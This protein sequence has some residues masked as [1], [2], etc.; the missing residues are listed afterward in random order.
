MDINKYWE[1]VKEHEYQKQL[2][3]SNTLDVTIMLTNECNFR[4]EYCFELNKEPTFLTKETIIPFIDAMFDFEDHKD[5]WKDFYLDDR[6]YRHIHFLFFGGEPFLNIKLV[7][8]ILDYFKKKCDENPEKYQ[9]RW[10]DM[11]G[12]IITNGSL[13]KTKDADEFFKKWGNRIGVAVTCEGCKEFHDAGRKTKD[14]KP[15]FDMCLDGIYYVKEKY[16]KNCNVQGI[17]VT[18]KNVQYIYKAYLGM[19]KI[20]NFIK[21]QL[22]TYS[23]VKWSEENIKEFDKQYQLVVEDALKSPNV[24]LSMFRN[25]K[26]E[27]NTVDQ[28]MFPGCG[29][30]RGMI[31]VGADG[32]LYPC[33]N[34]GSIMEDP[35]HANDFTLGDTKNGITENGMKVLTEKIYGWTHKRKYTEDECK[36]CTFPLHCNDCPAESYLLNRDITLIN[37]NNCEMQKIEHKWALIYNYYK[38]KNEVK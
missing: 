1:K 12:T 17:T 34:F 35:E 7:T 36:M 5:Y 37:K 31:A 13:F 15:T 33:Y 32:F 24:I 22:Q 6:D 14:G 20:S 26:N 9:S 18:P 11:Y 27:R 25:F 3:P 10:N 21:I 28:C 29:L 4:C 38:D 8:F 16:N 30:G 23:E 2:R 19:K